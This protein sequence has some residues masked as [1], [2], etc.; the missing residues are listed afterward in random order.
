ME[1]LQPGDPGSVG[2]YQLVGRLGAGGMGQVFLGETPGGRKVAVK[3]IH[4]GHAKDAQ[5][6]ERFAREIAAARRVGGFHTAPV[7]DADP[8]AD[9]PWMVTAFIDGP[10]L[11]D[12]VGRDGPL[13]PGRIRALG[14]G[15]AE[16]LAAI[17]AEGLVHRDLKPGNVILASDGPRIIDFGIAR[18]AD[19]TRLTT[20]GAVIGTL[21]YMSPEQLGGDPAGPASDVFSLGGVLAF[22]ATARPPFGSGS[23]A[24]VINRI[25]SQPPDLAAVADGQVRQLIASCL[26]KSPAG[27]P[28]LAAILAALTRPGV[29]K[30]RVIQVSPALTLTGHEDRVGGVAFSPD[31]RLLASSSNDKTVRL[32]DP[33]SGAHRR[34]LTGRT[35]WVGGLAF[36]PDGR[37]LAGVCGDGAVWLWDPASGRHRRTLTGGMGVVGVTFSLDGRLLAS[38]GQGEAQGMRTY[39]GAVRLWD[40]ASGKQRRILDGHA[41]PPLGVPGPV[42]GV[43][44]SPDGGLL[45]CGCWDRTVQLWDPAS[46]TYR[47]A[48]LGHENM[49]EGVAFS[50]DG[51]LLASCSW[52]RTVRLW[53]PASGTHRRTL[54]GHTGPV[55]GVAF[56]P[57]GRL[58][59][60][61]SDDKTV[62]LW[63]LASGTHRRTLVGH[64]KG[65]TAVAFSP[66]GRLLASSSGDKT[67]R[68]WLVTPAD[69]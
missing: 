59:A 48:L 47:R 22:A 11:E 37:L 4:P 42:F 54:A 52:D 10:S 8:H 43:A 39:I 24:A 62:R 23:A 50:P 55:F 25:L 5:F 33:A 17:H 67:V 53:D 45:A 30:D 51:R 68:L 2:P 20:V 13:P 14:A 66:D 19:E 6:R 40:P 49:V 16:G 56:S 32:W 69:R 41:G 34:T 7:V 29:A 9:P 38:C 31:G 3:L 18:A 36:S 64:T 57:D 60:S 27:R 46:G 63:D 1:S 61:C 28:A 21:A 65:V 35:E 15:L 44:F 58:L 12:T 26:T